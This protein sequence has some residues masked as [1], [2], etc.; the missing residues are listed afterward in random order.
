MS[1]TLVTGATGFI[2]RRLALKL[3][4]D[5]LHVRCLVRHPQ[6]AADLVAAGIELVEGDV[7]DPIAVDKA[8]AGAEVIYHLASVLGPRMCPQKCMLSLMLP[9]RGR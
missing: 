8:C 4:A 7:S 6:Q 9:G 1:L 5:R 3:A 2:G